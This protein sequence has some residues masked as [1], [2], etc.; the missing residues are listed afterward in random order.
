MCRW[1]I[2][3]LALVSLTASAAAAEILCPPK[4]ALTSAEHGWLR[5]VE[6][7]WPIEM[8]RT[9]NA[10]DPIRWRSLTGFGASACTTPTPVSVPARPASPPVKPIAPITCT[11]TA[12]TV[13]GQHVLFCGLA[14]AKPANR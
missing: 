14:P 9:L 8:L 5:E 2:G 7:I 6:H 1:L 10:A 3:T 13:P 12:T 11:K 4:R